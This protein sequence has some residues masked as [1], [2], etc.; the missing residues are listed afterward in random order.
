[1][2]GYSAKAAVLAID[3]TAKCDKN[4]AGAFRIVTAKATYDGYASS[5]GA[6][7]AAYFAMSGGAGLAPLAKPSDQLARVRKF[8]AEYM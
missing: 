7:I 6:W 2:K 4:E 8:Q 5:F 3:P 1:M